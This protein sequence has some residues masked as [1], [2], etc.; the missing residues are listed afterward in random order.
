[1]SFAEQHC[2]SRALAMA[3]TDLQRVVDEGERLSAELVST[4]RHAASELPAGRG[5]GVSESIPLPRLTAATN[6]RSFNAAIERNEALVDE[7]LVSLQTALG[8][9]VRGSIYSPVLPEGEP[10]QPLAPAPEPEPEPERELEPPLEIDLANVLYRVVN[11]GIIR[12]GFETDSKK[13]G[14][15]ERGDTIRPLEIR[16]NNKGQQ[17]VRFVYAV[18][19]RVSSQ[20]SAFTQRTSE[21]IY[22]ACDSESPPAHD[23]PCV[24]GRSCQATLSA[25]PV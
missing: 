5:T 8:K 14:T 4:L 3:G 25:G 6:R 19:P 15:L 18:G 24:V 21:S 22:C 9:R 17:R 13:Q 20:V 10:K 12:A 16:V 7:L 23:S 1:M 11:R 2:C